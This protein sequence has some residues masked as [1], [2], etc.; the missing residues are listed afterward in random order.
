MQF[1]LTEIYSEEGAEY[2]IPYEVV[3]LLSEKLNQLGKSIPYYQTM[4]K[5]SEYMLL[6][7]IS[8]TLLSDKLTIPRP[9]V[10]KKKGIIEFFIKIP[11]KKCDDFASS[12]DYVLSYIENGVLMI[13]DKYKVDQ[14]GVQES[15]VAVK[16][17][18]HENQQF[19]KKKYDKVLSE[20]NR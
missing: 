18:I 11:F 17:N 14:S 15:F 19:Y 20:W 12:M 13:F 2:Y 1:K 8:A 9:I 6:L 7:Y 10:L 4:F 3:R 5:S 16:K